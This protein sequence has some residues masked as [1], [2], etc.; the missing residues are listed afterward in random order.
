MSPA[1]PAGFRVGH[2]TDRDRWTGC[3][4]VLAPE[5]A[6]SSCE[7]RGGGPGTRETDLLSPASAAPGAH[8]LLLT[9]GSAFGLT[10]ADGVV[11]FLAERGVGFQ[12]RVALVP[13]VAA[14]VV[15]DL[16]LGD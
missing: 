7:V 3:T 4:V 10:A 11:T 5:G 8:A 1:L 2:W 16:A 9:G 13:L 6:F 12:T 14:A 15:Y